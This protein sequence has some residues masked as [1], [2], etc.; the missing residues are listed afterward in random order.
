M[1]KFLFLTPYLP[2]PPHSGGPR[3]LHGL[4]TGLARSHSVSVLSFVE[5]HE[6]H[7]IALEATREYCAEVVTVE[8]D[9]YGLSNAAKRRLQL[10]SMLSFKS[11]ER[12]V[13]H[14]PALQVALDRMLEQTRYDLVTVEFAQMAQYRF[15]DTTKRVLDE[16][17]IEYDILYRTYRLENQPGR[18]LY[19]YVN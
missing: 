17:N 7:T 14:R 9:Y 5:P 10:K 6:D 19:N 1:K 11:Y 3:R 2:S 18:K 4:M 12:L 16:H 13:Y 15:L 8:N